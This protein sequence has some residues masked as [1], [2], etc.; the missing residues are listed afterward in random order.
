MI[1]M[2]VTIE[3]L[4]N[5]MEFIRQYW[6]VQSVP[7]PAVAA[8][9]ALV[10]GFVL[11]FWGARLLR[12]CYVIAFIIAGAMVG[13]D[14]ARDREADPLIGLVI[15]GGVA[16]VVGHLLY[17]WWVGLTAGA[18]AVLIVILVGAP[19]V[20]GQAESFAD[21]LLR[22]AT[23]QQLFAGAEA[24]ERSQESPTSNPAGGTAPSVDWSAV[25]A[26]LQPAEG[27]T[28]PT[29]STCARTWGRSVWGAAPP[30]LRNVSLLAVVAGLLGLALGI[31]LPRFATILGTSVAGVS[32]LAGGAAF[33]L[34][35]H[36]PGTWEFVHARPAGLYV[37]I[38]LM[39]VVSLAFQARRGKLRQLA[40]ATAPA[41]G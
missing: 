40:P 13:I 22:Q 33:F 23:G 2:S 37:A 25:A 32:A 8:G 41:A 29:L 15:G 3:R 27:Q 38:G 26:S 9:A 36:A 39:L 18:S 11:A 31:F 30:G 19:E 16:G 6:S 14:F 24:V 4:S 5:W 28:R 21:A 12:A 17:R 35:C 34:S 1:D 20:A 7:S 10:V